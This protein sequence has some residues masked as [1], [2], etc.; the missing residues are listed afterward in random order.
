VEEIPESATIRRET[1]PNNDDEQP[2]AIK[3]QEPQQFEEIPE[4][5]FE[6]LPVV[7]SQTNTDDPQAINISMLA[8]SYDTTINVFGR[9]R[10]EL[11]QLHRLYARESSSPL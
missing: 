2:L 5:I 8:Q 11:L 3:L 1:M 4:I 6:N 7:E 10:Q 9:F